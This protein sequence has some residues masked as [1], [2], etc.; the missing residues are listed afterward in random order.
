MEEVLKQVLGKLVK[1][2]KSREQGIRVGRVSKE[3]CAE[4]K[5]VTEDHRASHEAIKDQ[6]EAF[7]EKL[8]A[9]HDCTPFNDRKT[10]A[11]EKI[12]DELGLAQADRTKR[13]RINHEER[14]VYLLE[15]TND[16]E[17]IEEIEIGIRI[18]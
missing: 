16:E 10:E 9:Q 17:E 7:I 13:Y 8:E 15:G 4:L 18:Q 1:E 11:W 14:V 3:I 2:I 5:K 6:I 12:Y